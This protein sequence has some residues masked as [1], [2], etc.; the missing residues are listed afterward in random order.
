M[1]V[2]RHIMSRIPA[3]PY[4]S[5]NTIQHGYYKTYCFTDGPALDNQTRFRHKNTPAQPCLCRQGSR[6]S[7]EKF[8][9]RGILC[10]DQVFIASYSVSSVGLNL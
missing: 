2:K 5:N 7:G 9:V 10:L 1:V 4:S 6:T 3:G 8:V